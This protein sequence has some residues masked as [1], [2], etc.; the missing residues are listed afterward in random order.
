MPPQ[1]EEDVNSPSS[2]W[3]FI[4][5]MKRPFGHRPRHIN[6][7]YIQPDNPFRQFQPGEV[8]TGEVIV[9][10]AKPLDMTHLVIC[11]HGFAQVYKTPNNPGV[12]YKEY[13]AALVTGRTNK[14]GG[15]YGNG[16][17]SLF[18]DEAVLCGEGRLKEGLFRFGFELHFPLEHIPS[19]IDFERGTV[20]YMITATL[21]RPS[22]ASIINPVITCDPRRVSFLDDIDIAPLL[23]PKPRV[24]TL[25][26]IIRRQRTRSRRQRPDNSNA[27]EPATTRPT[28]GDPTTQPDSETP[29]SPGPSE[30]SF[31]SAISSGA[32]ASATGE[33]AAPSQSTRN[34]NSVNGAA[35]DP[36]PAPSSKRPVNR[37]PIITSV[38]LGAAGYLRGDVIDM[39]IHISHTK[40]IKSLHGVIATLYRQARVDM[41]P[42]LPLISDKDDELYP[43]SRTGLGGLSL[44]SA[45]SCH[46]FRKDLD[47]SFASIIINPDTLTAEIKTT[48]RVPEDAFP[49][50]TTVPGA[51]ISFKYYVEVILD[52]QGKLIGLDK[53]LPTPNVP[54]LSSNYRNTNDSP[55]AHANVYTGV[56]FDTED[57]RRE[58]NVV[59]CNFEVIIGTRDSKRTGRWR[60]ASS[61]SQTHASDSLSTAVPDIIEPFSR[62]PSRSGLPLTNMP[63]IPGDPSSVP[64]RNRSAS[65]DNG[66]SHLAVPHRSNTF[67]LLRHSDPGSPPIPSYDS[68]SHPPAF[69]IPDL[70]DEH[71]DEKAR[72]RRLLPSEPPTEGGA[73]SS[74][75]EYAPS[76]PGLP[77]LV[78]FNYQNHH[79]HQQQQQHHYHQEH[80][81]SSASAPAYQPSA[82]TMPTDDKVELERQRLMALASAPPPTNG[83][84]GPSAP[85]VDA[86]RDESST[87]PNAP[88]VRD[89]DDLFGFDGLGLGRGDLPRYER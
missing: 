36:Q 21:T 66:L 51:M 70:P 11:L 79:H 73:S 59:S 5:R 37:K 16:F 10:V 8:V 42:A 80:A 19:S 64:F 89:D 88:V 28:Q 69:S 7:F 24:V 23:Q 41:H 26:P 56:M 86:Q 4:S 74:G 57:I 33:S 13:N 44:S 48:L 20:S 25:E 12:G 40:P 63:P 34:G 49:S 81:E 38:Q 87:A 39:K 54:S 83:S 22:R 9:K 3:G 82:N 62:V 1:P 46:L 31:D 14:A 6:E 2:R 52:I 45:G 65:Q 35:I 50:I 58:R 27:P 67:P 78:P 60:D 77:D 55:G 47:Q 17:A 76:A 30:E 43:K 68:V 32:L 18:E 71:E 75:L 85:P 53:Y 72:L 29:R 61:S 15:Y 84:T